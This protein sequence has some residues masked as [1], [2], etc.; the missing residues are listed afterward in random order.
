[1]F[2]WKYATRSHESYIWIWETKL[3]LGTRK[4]IQHREFMHSSQEFIYEL[5]K[6]AKNIILP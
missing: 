1:M 2:D 3:F 4:E 5:T 6:Q